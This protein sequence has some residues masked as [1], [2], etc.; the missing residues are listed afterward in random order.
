MKCLGIDWGNETHALVLVGPHGTVLKE[1]TIHHTPTALDTLLQHL[2]RE[3]GPSEVLVAM[4]PGAAILLDRLYDAGYTVYPIN[5]KQL[6]RFRDRHFPS[7]AKDDSRDALV[8]ATALARDRDRLRPLAPQDPLSEELVARA[9]TRGDR[10][11]TGR[12]ANQLLAVLRRY[13]PTVE[14]LEPVMDDPFFLDLLTAFPDPGAARR[15]VRPVRRLLNNHRIQVLTW[16][17][18]SPSSGAPPSP[19]GRTSC[20]LPGRGPGPRGPDPAAQRPGQ[21]RPPAPGRPF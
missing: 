18:S 16:R 11:P 20:R 17:T 6:D 9:Q 8:A 5:P 21:D 19:C 1:W 13:F 15:P 14:L 7:G 10:P 4:E 2:K 12:L 3:G